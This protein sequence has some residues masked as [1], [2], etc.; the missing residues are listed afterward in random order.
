ME[1]ENMEANGMY[2]FDVV[3]NLTSRALESFFRPITQPY[4][5]I[6]VIELDGIII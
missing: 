5:L 4:L 1:N 6:E 2:L 3:S